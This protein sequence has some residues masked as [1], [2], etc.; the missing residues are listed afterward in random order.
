MRISDWSSDVCS[1]DLAVARGGDAAVLRL[2]EANARITEIRR[3]R[4]SDIV[5][6][7]VVDD[8]RFPVGKTLRL[9]RI[10]RLAE[11]M[12]DAEG[13]NDHGDARN[14]GGR[15]AAHQRSLA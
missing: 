5:G 2:Q 3:D 4:A 1:S 6:R 12:R 14:R 7:A 15:R 9:H 13:R 10:E 11:K 8:D